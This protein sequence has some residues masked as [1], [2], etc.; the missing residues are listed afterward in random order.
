MNFLDFIFDNLFIIAIVVFGI[1]NLFSRSTKSNQSEQRKQQSRPS[2][3]GP[4]KQGTSHTNAGL[5]KQ[6]TSRTNYEPN[7]QDSSPTSDRQGPILGRMVERVENAFEEI[8]NQYEQTKPSENL[9]EQQRKQYEQLKKEV[10]HEYATNTD[11]KVDKVVKDKSKL[12]TTNHSSREV[13]NIDV[14][15]LTNRKGLVQGMIMSEVLGPPRGL[16]PYRSI[17]SERR[18]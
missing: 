13:A 1:I 12:R 10:Q 2:N 9:A 16:K 3:Y 7:K 17:I 11:E 6:E 15:S 18:N 4:S 5:P 14:K 8:T